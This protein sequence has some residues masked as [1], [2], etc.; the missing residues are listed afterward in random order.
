MNKLKDLMLRK[1]IRNMPVI[2][3]VAEPIP[4]EVVEVLEKLSEPKKEKKA[5]KTK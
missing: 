5:K 4:A 1:K 2:E 3:E